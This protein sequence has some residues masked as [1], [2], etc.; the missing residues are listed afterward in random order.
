[1]TTNLRNRLL[2]VGIVS[3]IAA[4]GLVGAAVRY[5]SLHDSR[6]VAAAPTPAVVGVPTGEVD[7]GMAVY[8]LPTVE[9]SVS[10]SEALARIARED[11]LAAATK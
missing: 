1:M 2:V 10:R 8:R 7:R 11:A 6:P 5:S 3:A 4:S 9:V